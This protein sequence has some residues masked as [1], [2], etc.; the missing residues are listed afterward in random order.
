[1]K[2]SGSTWYV[3]LCYYTASLLNSHATLRQRRGIL[4]TVT[5]FCW[6]PFDNF[7]PNSLHKASEVGASAS[8]IGASF[9]EVSR[10]AF[11]HDALL[12]P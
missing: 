11:L 6:L 2:Y 10:A 1:M 9:F 12:Q 4:H 5:A 7:A 8:E 3:T